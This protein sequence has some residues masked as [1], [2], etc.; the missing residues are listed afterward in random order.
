[1][2]IFYIAEKHFVISIVT[3]LII[4]LLQGAILGRGIRN[5]FPK[6]KTH[7]RIVSTS[8][9]VLFSVNAVANI[10][11]FASP[12]KVQSDA[13]R[14]PENIQEGINMAIKVLGFDLGFWS[15]IAMFVSVILVVFFRFAELPSVARYFIFGLS[16]IFLLVGI[17]SKFTD[18]TPSQFQ[19]ILYSTYHFGITVA[20]FFVTRRKETDIFTEIK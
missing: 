20:I 1:M 6:L 10:L 14:T 11:K 12:E 13:L 9:L 19:I 2:D 18:F 5:R 4:G 8:L 3:I 17:I 7:A 15:V 16:F